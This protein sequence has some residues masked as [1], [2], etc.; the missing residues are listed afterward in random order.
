MD[1]ADNDN[2]RGEVREGGRDVVR[3]EEEE[4][5]CEEED[6]HHPHHHGGEE[7]NSRTLGP[8]SLGSQSVS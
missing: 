1:A 7:R 4:E 2:G 6:T 5:V 3:E 8:F